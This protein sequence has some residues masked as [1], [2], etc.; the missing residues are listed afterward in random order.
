LPV[1][2]YTEKKKDSVAF[3]IRHEVNTTGKE[4]RIQ[5]TDGSLV[6]L[7]NNSEVTYREPF[8]NIR[9][10]TLSGKA[11]FKVVHDQT[12]PFTVTSGDISTMDMGTEF[13]VTAF[14]NKSHIIVRL[15]E[16][17]VVIRPVDKTNKR[18]KQDV[19]LLPG[20]EFV[21]GSQPAINK[22]RINRNAAPEQVLQQE[23]AGD[24]PS[25]PEISDKPYF[26]FNNQML[27]DVFDD[28]AALYN[29][30]ILYNKKDVQKIYFTRKYD[31][32]DSLENILEEIGTIHHLTITK[33]E[34]AYIIS[35]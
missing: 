31:R 9:D 4:K 6:V 1:V 28:L 20:Q 12:K 19:Y 18:M 2:K 17:K 13:T 8:S 10:I 22:F 27:G 5:L 34:N 7:A 14:R 33:K 35:R 11:F 16:G 32:T 21:Y 26:M 23:Q 15:Y 3:V 30:K 24:N 25:L 29:V